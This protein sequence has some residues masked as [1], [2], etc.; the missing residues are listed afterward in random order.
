MLKTQAIT[1]A[2]RTSLLARIQTALVA[3]QLHKRQPEL[4]LYFLFKQTQGDLDLSAPLWKL[5]VKGA[6]SSELSKLLWDKTADAIVHSYKDL[7]IIE[8]ENTN[9]NTENIIVLPRADQ[10]DL[11]L[12]KKEAMINPPDKITILTSSPRRM[13][14]LANF[15]PHALPQSLQN[16]PIHFQAI[17]GN[18]TTRLEK[19]IAVGSEA[20]AI[21]LAKAGLDR[22]LSQPENLF[23]SPDLLSLTELEKNQQTIREILS[24]CHFMVLPLSRCPN[25]P[26]QGSMCVEIRAKDIA[27]KSIIQKIASLEMGLKAKFEALCSQ[28][29]R[30][31]LAGF[32]GGCQQKIGIAYLHRNSYG[33]IYYMRGI[34]ERQ[35]E[36]YEY[37]LEREGSNEK[38]KVTEK[39]IRPWPLKGEALPLKRTPLAIL[40]P[41]G[42]SH[43][44]ISRSVSWPTHWE[45]EGRTL[46]AAGVQTLFNLAKRGIW[47]HGCAD[48]LGEQEDSNIETL[49]EDTLA[50]GKFTKLSHS[51]NNYTSRY[52]I[53]ATYKIELVGS[54][55]GLKERT[56]FFWKSAQQFDLI[57]SYLPELRK[58][59]HACGLGLTLLYLKEKLPYPP[60]VYIDHTE[61]LNKIKGS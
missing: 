14:L 41:T 26:G 24:Q 37:G 8:V 61:W 47:V 38:Q 25:A 10:R 28:K 49:V 58:A 36:F 52:P 56:H 53:I 39:N 22:L 16:R 54:I 20:Q 6:F 29:E 17:R 12:Y 9:N 13:Y 40:Q 21:V 1:I 50:I 7:P 35:E 60:E 43:F 11:L 30:T 3:K 55:E 23:L 59:K 48:G 57:M 27:T 33:N 51:Y 44:W 4:Q 42:L 15:L 46:W 2:S 5:P 34:N 32:G 18:I 31:L 19:F 45:T